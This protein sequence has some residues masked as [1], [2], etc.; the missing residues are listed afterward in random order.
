MKKIVILALILTLSIILCETA[1]AAD[2]TTE[3]VSIATNGSEG[4]LDSASAAISADGRY[5]AFT[6]G[7]SNLVPDDTN[8]AYDIFV[9]DR[10]VK[11]IERVSVGPLGVQA[12][13]NSRC[14][15]ISAD[16]RF[17]AFNSVASNLVLGDTNQKT[18]VFVY[19]RYTHTTELI[20]KGLGGAQSDKDSW[21]CALSADGRYVSFWSYA[22]NLVSDDTNN[23][24]DVFVYDRNS[25]S[26]ERVSL[27][28]G[29]SQ[30]NGWSGGNCCPWISAD[31]RFVVFD[32]AATNLVP[33][34]TN[35]LADL[36]VHDRILHTTERVNLGPGGVQADG[37]SAWP[38]ISSDG[39]YVVYF[40]RA[41]NLVSDDTNRVG[42]V[43]LYDR[44]TH[45]TQRISVGVGGIQATGGFSTFP[46]IS[47][48]NRYVAF[49]STATNLIMDDTNGFCDIFVY[50]LISNTMERVSV[51][52]AGEQGNENSPFYTFPTISAN[53]RYVAFESL[54]SNL[55]AVDNNGY[56]DI[57][58]RDRGERTSNIKQEVL[59]FSENGVYK[60]AVE[61]VAMLKT[62]VSV[63][64]LMLAVMLIFTGLLNSRR[65]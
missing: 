7:S 57:F 24:A 12:N 42:D 3:R 4:D 11:T 49:A 13:G 2:P 62:G 50:D 41:T 5:V 23:R 53:G 60:V 19:D 32:S 65:K 17:V 35:N 6:S 31:G 44:I 37:E 28:P 29:F 34:D 10:L 58:V 14:A 16:G 39:R 55:V 27:G 64:I 8:G 21:W 47:A 56:A 22:S 54:A 26:M 1:T 18:D 36:F 59:S 9:Y 20:T 43:F 48:N 63:W 61:S 45:K 15:F 46:V 52:T 38:A 40:S 51:G 25:F 33:D 30:G